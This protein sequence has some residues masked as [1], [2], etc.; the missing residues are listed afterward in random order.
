MI[1]GLNFSLI[2]EFGI[3]KSVILNQKCL[4]LTS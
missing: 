3:L 4:P 2:L 1:A